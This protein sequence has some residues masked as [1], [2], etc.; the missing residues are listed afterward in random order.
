MD[1][2]MPYLLMENQYTKIMNYDL[3]IKISILADHA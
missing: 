3:H 2:S 1:R